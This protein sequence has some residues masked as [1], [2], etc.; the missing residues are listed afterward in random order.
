MRGEIMTGFMRDIRKMLD[1]EQKRRNRPKPYKISLMVFS[2]EKDNRKHG[3]D[4]ERWVKEG[5]VDGDL[6]I[7]FFANLTSFATPDVKYYKKITAGTKV[8]VYPFLVSWKSPG[9]KEVVDKADAFYKDGAD[10]LGA[11]D[12]STLSTFQDKGEGQ[13][14]NL[15]GRL[16]DPERVAAF[17]RSNGQATKRIELIRF[18]ENTYNRFIPNTGF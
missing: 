3:L 4:V 7:A 9:W 11:W 14:F 10:G 15:L 17:K 16:G 12:I 8:G 18:G 1:E 6:G 13:L 2:T 5:L